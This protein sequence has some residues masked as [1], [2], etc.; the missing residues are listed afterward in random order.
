MALSRQAK[1]KKNEGQLEI[2]GLKEF[3]IQ[4]LLLVLLELLLVLVLSVLVEV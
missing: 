2:G 3:R 4:L 1:F